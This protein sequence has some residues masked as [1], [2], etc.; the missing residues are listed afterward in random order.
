MTAYADIDNLACEDCEFHFGEKIA[1]KEYAWSFP[2][3][4]GTN[5]G[6]LVEGDIPYMK[7]FEDS[8][9]VDEEHKVYGYKIPKYNKVLFYKNRTFFVGD[10]AGQVLPFTYEGIYY[11]MSS[12][13]ILADVL[14]NN[15]EPVE[16][17]NRWNKKYL[18]KFQTLQKL[19]KIFLYNDF[20]I[21]IM[22]KMYQSPSV[23]KTM[24]DL[25]LT[26]RKVEINF[27]FFLKIV[28]KIF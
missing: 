3:S 18:K 20:M 16:Y 27:R 13:K 4:N 24:L 5:I 21:K 19:Q 12:A 6:T 14:A 26:D 28:K 10:S 2:E 22:M 8:L 7:N 25:W 15:F 11:A 17:E 23:Q 9:G 1:A